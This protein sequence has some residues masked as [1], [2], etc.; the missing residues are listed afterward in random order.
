[1]KYQGVVIS[2]TN[3]RAVVTTEDFQC[4]YIKRKATFYVGKQV[5]FSRSE[6]IRTDS[7]YARLV[8]SVACILFILTLFINFTG[9]LN[10][11]DVLSGREV[12]A[13]VGVDINPSLELKI[14]N[15]GKVLGLV[16][17]ND[18]ARLLIDKL[19][20]DKV[21]VNEA[22]ETI[23]D[24]VRKITGKSE[25]DKSYVLISGTLNRKNSKNADKYQTEKEKLDRMMDDMESLLEAEREVE[26]YYIQSS[27]YEREEARNKGMS[28][29]RYVLYKNSE[30]SFSIEEAKKVNVKVL[31]RDIIEDGAQQDDLKNKP[32]PTPS[33]MQN[34]AENANVEATPAQTQQATEGT[35]SELSTPSATQT[36]KPTKKPEENTKNNIITTPIQTKAPAITPTPAKN[37]DSLYMKFESYNYIMHFIKHESYRFRISQDIDIADDAVF[38]IVP[39][40]ADPSCISFESKNYPGYYLKHENYEI[41]LKKNDGS[42]QFSADATFRKVPGLADSR[43]ISFQ[44]YNYPD[45]FIR[46]RKYL[47][48]IEEINTELEKKDA[49]YI[50]IRVRE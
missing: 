24:E 28:T 4:F 29:G 17:F 23:I 22:V 40:L 38:K 44:S 42:E 43:Y 21:S 39:G 45:R 50:G 14:D 32:E 46:H 1:M 9:L 34:V 36:A 20:I 7:I 47:L 15:E 18:E 10:I 19:N 13:Y 48:Y 3:D 16:P 37:Q 26:I 30:N 6:I 5:E 31:I 2:L 27:V 11:S 33:P 41:I 25:A 12:F 49:T 35:D 8:V